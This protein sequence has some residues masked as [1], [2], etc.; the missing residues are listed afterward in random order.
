MHLNKN[1]I[2]LLSQYFSD[3][4]KIIFGS[5]V[6]GFFLPGIVGAITIPVFWGGIVATVSC[7]LFSMNL[8]K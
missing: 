7:L 1:Q 3:L 2:N 8:L 6:L 5:A 4:S